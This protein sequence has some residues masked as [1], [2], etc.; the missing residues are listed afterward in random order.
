MLTRYNPF[1]GSRSL[2]LFNDFDN[3]FRDLA[4]SN[5]AFREAQSLIP[6]ADVF[7]S[8]DAVR[9]KVDLPGHDPKDIH[10]R[11]EGDVLTIES[12][13]KV[14]KET[15]EGSY[16]RTERSYGKYSRSFV[17]PQTVDGSKPEARFD[18]GV[19]TVNLPKREEVKPRS[20]EVKVQS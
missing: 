20:I 9:V 1:N 10:V 4:V 14:E 8:A 17:L 12:E 13:R 5:G 2:S 19:L 3:L 6:V 15:Q 16:L 18:H 11:L 7:E